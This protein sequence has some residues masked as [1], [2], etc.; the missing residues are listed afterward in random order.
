M[1]IVFGW[2]VYLFINF[3]IKFF[4]LHYETPADWAQEQ[5]GREHEWMTKWTKNAM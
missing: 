2:F 4:L 1:L 5:A 3:S